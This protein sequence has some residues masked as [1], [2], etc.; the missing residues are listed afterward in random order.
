[1]TWATQ[2]PCGSK[3]RGSPSSFTRRLHYSRP[4]LAGFTPRPEGLYRRSLW[5]GLSKVN[6]YFTDNLNP[7]IRQR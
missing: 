3:L 7:I 5:R 2:S 4:S 1:M 6:P